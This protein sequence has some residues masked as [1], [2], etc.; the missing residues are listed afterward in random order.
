M[1][2][3][4]YFT[5]PYCYERVSMLLDLSTEGQIYVEDC[6]ICCNPVEID[7]QVKDGRIVSFDARKQ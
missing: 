1:D 4:Y 7:Y 2:E 6:E 3:E 5:C